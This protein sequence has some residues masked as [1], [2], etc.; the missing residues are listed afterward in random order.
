[1][2]ISSS[3]LGE[4][5]V[6]DGAVQIFVDKFGGEWVGHKEGRMH[7][8]HAIMDRRRLLRHI[9]APTKTELEPGQ[10]FTP[11]ARHSECGWV[12]EA[13]PRPG[14]TCG[15]Q[16]L[17]VRTGTVD[18]QWTEDSRDA[19]RFA[20]EDDVRAFM[21]LS[22]LSRLLIRPAFKEWETPCSS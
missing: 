2:T 18:V 9:D 10:S 7:G 16:Y 21:A 13:P 3:Q 17:Y 5:R 20:R 22:A 1:M 15:T 8:Q 12:V 14:Q 19:L 4:I 11:F 6:R